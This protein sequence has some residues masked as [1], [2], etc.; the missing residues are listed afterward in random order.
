MKASISLENDKE[1]MWGILT[2]NP[3]FI[4]HHYGEE[5]QTLSKR[6]NKKAFHSRVDEVLLLLMNTVTDPIM[7]VAVV[8]CWLTEYQL[9]V[10][11]ASLKS[12]DRFHEQ[13][14]G[15]VLNY[16]NNIPAV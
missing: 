9:P 4:A 8:K 1:L 14:G 11:P 5:L 13:Y 7:V 3:K 12:F 15:I 16:S 10:E 6:K 2:A